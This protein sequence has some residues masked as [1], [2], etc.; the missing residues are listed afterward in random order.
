MFVVVTALSLGASA[1]DFILLLSYS[2]SFNR[3]LPLIPLVFFLFWFVRV[4]YE[5]RQDGF[6]AGIQHFEDFISSY[7]RSE[8]FW[9][10]VWGIS[11]VF[12]LSLFF[13]LGKSLIPHL[14]TYSW[15]PLF[16]QWDRAVHFGHYP[17]EFI[18]PLVNATGVPE[19]TGYVYF[20]FYIYL[21]LMSVYAVFFE[22]DPR[23]VHQFLWGYVL[24]WIVYGM[25]AATLL[26][27]V[28]PVFYG[29]FFEGVD[30]YAGYVQE[31]M[32]VA[33]AHD[34]GMVAAYDVIY[35]WA[36]DESVIDLNGI[37]AMPSMHVA[38]VALGVF[39]FWDEGWCA[40]AGMIIYLALTILC[41]V[42]LALH[43]AID[44]YASIAL[45]AVLWWGI[46]CALEKM[47]VETS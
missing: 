36:V 34:I 35:E 9:N 38:L 14:T 46:G 24:S 31:L 32:A 26:A 12:F 47:H 4:L 22:K 33:K 29:R 30:P 19:V 5:R 27:S 16:A 25:G 6:A 18:A 13:S 23:R 37:S 3:F 1:G 44:A 28:G 41:T 8:R 15:D 11:I 45:V 40:R 10:I 2:K 17:H 21:F 43:Y 20:S 39:Y 7:V 42:Y